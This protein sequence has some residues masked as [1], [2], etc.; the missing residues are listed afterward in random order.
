MT[1]LVVGDHPEVRAIIQRRQA[2]GLD[3]HDEVWEGI[4]HMLPYAE[5]GHG[6]VETQ[7]TLVLHPYARAAGL[8][9]TGAFNLG[10]KG[11]YRAP[12]LG[13][14]VPGPRAAY[15]PTSTMVIEVLSP[16]DETFAKFDF[17]AACGVKEILVADPDNRSVRCWAFTPHGPIE[18]RSSAVLQVDCDRLETAVE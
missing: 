12:D 13:V 7:L 3:G 11:D 6:E 10:S 5:S 1:V 2:L 15:L 9:V 14:R 4:H 17:Y 8:H 18:S 16:D